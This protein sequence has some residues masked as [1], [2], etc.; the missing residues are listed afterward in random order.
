MSKWQEPENK[1]EERRDYSPHPVLRCCSWP[2]LVKATQKPWMTKGSPGNCEGHQ[3]SQLRD[4]S[5]EM[6]PPVKQY[7]LVPL[8]WSYIMKYFLLY[9][10]TK[11]TNSHLFGFLYWSSLCTLHDVRDEEFF[12]SFTLPSTEDCKTYTGWNSFLFQRVPHFAENPENVPKW[13]QNN[14]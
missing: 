7:L 6:C 5:W 13:H 9:R 10:R 8:A 2:T 14:Y 3:M 12:C 1:A 4:P 11:Q